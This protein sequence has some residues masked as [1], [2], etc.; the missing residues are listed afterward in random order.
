MRSHGKVF[1]DIIDFLVLTVDRSPDPTSKPWYLSVMTLL[2]TILT[3][4]KI[5]DNCPKQK[6]T[7]E[8]IGAIL[9]DIHFFFD[10]HSQLYLLEKYPGQER[11]IQRLYSSVSI[12]SQKLVE[13]ICGRVRGASSY[14][15]GVSP[16]EREGRL[17]EAVR[18]YI[19]GSLNDEERAYLTG[20]GRMF[21]GDRKASESHF[22]TSMI[23]LYRDIVNLLGEVD[24]KLLLSLYFSFSAQML[25]VTEQDMLRHFEFERCEVLEFPDHFYTDLS[26]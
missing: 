5:V 10:C 3:T 11:K 13:D 24:I 9:Q 6:R 19:H 1:K 2:E 14:L 25:A 17:K 7:P 21:I 4:R 22:L 12:G 18:R 15:V 26:T 23:L 16:L 8:I 20:R